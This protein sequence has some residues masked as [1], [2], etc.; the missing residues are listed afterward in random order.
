MYNRVHTFSILGLPGEWGGIF[1]FGSVGCGVCGVV[2]CGVCGVCVV[3]GVVLW[4]V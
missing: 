3:C 4:C 2:V 1:L